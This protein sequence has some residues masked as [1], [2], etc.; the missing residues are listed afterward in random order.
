[1]EFRG[2]CNIAAESLADPLMSPAMCCCPNLLRKSLVT[3]YHHLLANFS[4]GRDAR[5]NVEVAQQH[6]SAAV[7]GGWIVVTDVQNKGLALAGHL[8]GK[9]PLRY[10]TITKLTQVQN[11]TTKLWIQ[12]W[13]TSCRTSKMDS[14]WPNKSQWQRGYSL[15]SCHC[16][17]VWGRSRSPQASLWARHWKL[18]LKYILNRWTVS[19]YWTNGPRI[20]I[21]QTHDNSL[22]MTRKAQPVMFPPPEMSSRDTMLHH[23]LHCLLKVFIG[24][25]QALVESRVDLLG[26]NLGEGDWKN[27]LNILKDI[28]A[29][30]SLTRPMLSS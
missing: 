9:G 28:S 30:F 8:F 12:T 2:L 15:G 24:V 6:L 21:F 5:C 23:K 7:G 29:I 19:L 27:D 4:A 16:Q 20:S 18:I 17:P 3:K 11:T 26:N 13:C 1:M 10:P 25:I 14:V 22:T